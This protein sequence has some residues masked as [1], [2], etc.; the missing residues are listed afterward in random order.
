M[1]AALLHAELVC[2]A[3]FATANGIVAR[4]A[5]RLVLVGSGVDAKSLVVPGGRA[6]RP[7]TG[8]RVE[9]ARLRRGRPA[10]LQAW[11]LYA[12][13]AYAAG[14][15]ASP[16]TGGGRDR[17]ERVGPRAGSAPSTSRAAPDSCEQLRHGCRR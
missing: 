10:G 9:P 15:E 14:A 16:L 1:T 8:V 2:G 17:R 5:E 3:P 4:A 13:E 11:L 12:A 6:P 7:A